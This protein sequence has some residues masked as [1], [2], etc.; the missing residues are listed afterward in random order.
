MTIIIAANDID[1]DLEDLAERY[2][3]AKSPPERDQVADEA[4]AL[5]GG[6]I[7]AMIKRIGRGLGAD[8]LDGFVREAVV[9]TFENSGVTRIKR[10]DGVWESLVQRHKDG[11]AVAKRSGAC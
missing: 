10:S 9:E 6:R 3:R 2:D 5:I 7:K 11:H 4:F 8:D 1:I